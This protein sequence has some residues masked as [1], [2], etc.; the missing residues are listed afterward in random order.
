YPIGGAMADIMNE[1]LDDITVSSVPGGGT[2][3]PK[4]VSNGKADI[5]FSYNSI[6]TSAQEGE[7]PYDEEISGLK[8]VAK[9]YDMAWHVTT[10]ADSEIDSFQDIEDNEMGVKWAPN[11]KGTG[12]EWITS[13]VIE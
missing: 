1:E 7:D 10:P 2:S 9:V 4:A 11:E 3:N 8:A 12:D 13:K 5:G 6:L